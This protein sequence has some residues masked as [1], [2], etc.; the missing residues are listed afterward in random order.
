MRFLIWFSNVFVS[1]NFCIAFQ[2]SIHMIPTLPRRIYNTFT[3]RTENIGLFYLGAMNDGHLGVS[4]YPHFLVFYLSP[5]HVLP[6]I[7][8]GGKCCLSIDRHVVA[9]TFFGSSLIITQ[10]I[11]LSNSKHCEKYN[12][13]YHATLN[14]LYCRCM[15]L[16]K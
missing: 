15:T 2:Y 10:N 12:F 9:A 11:T 16:F 14:C 6:G 5:N 1:H 8:I 3:Y 7:G 13:H 4:R